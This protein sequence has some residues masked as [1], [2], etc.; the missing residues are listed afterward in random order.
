MKQEKLITLQEYIDSK[1]ITMKQFADITGVSYDLLNHK[2][3]IRGYRY[4]LDS[5]EKIYNGTKNMFG[6]GLTPWEYQDLC[7]FDVK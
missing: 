4:N 5:I 2:R 3:N 1:G 7:R 6:E